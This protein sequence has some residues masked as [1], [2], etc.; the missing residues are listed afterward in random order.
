MQNRGRRSDADLGFCLEPG[1]SASLASVGELGQL[2]Q[3]T[4]DD[5]SGESQGH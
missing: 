2:G 1:G 3:L 5:F 4:P